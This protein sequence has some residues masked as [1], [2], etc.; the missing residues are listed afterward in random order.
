[1]NEPIVTTS[2]L[3]RGWPLPTSSGDKEAKGRV[4]I[5]G[6]NVEVA[7]AT[8]LAA[9]AAMRA[10]AGKL[11]VAAPEPLAV[12]LGI[13]LPE[14]RV[15]GLPITGT[16]DVDPS[17]ADLIVELA[18]QCE[19]VLL[20]PGFEDPEAARA[21]LE[22]VVPRLDTALCIDALGLALLTHDLDA[23]QHLSGRVVLSPNLSEVFITLG[24]ESQYTADDEAAVEEA[25]AATRELASRSGAV[26]VSGAA[27]GFIAKPDG[28]AWSED[29]GGPGLGVS[30]S[31]DVK[32][33]IITGLMARGCDPEQAAVWGASTLR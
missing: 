8:L 27:V 3:L 12:A 10:G 19:A 9:E 16:G 1:M 33:G 4:L 32:A 15:I 22:G 17:A 30:G 14:A 24:R 26:V 13:A 28:T 5:V 7:G 11:Q 21:L 2:G 31:G 6:G 20:G 29:T 23:V 18:N 25:L